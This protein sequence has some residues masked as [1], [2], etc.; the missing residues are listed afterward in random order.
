[1]SLRL[2]ASALA[3]ALAVP[4]GARADQ[5]N[6]GKIALELQLP[7]ENGSSG[8][9][10]PTDEYLAKFFNSARCACDV[11]GSEQLY[12][13]EYT[14]QTPPSV[15]P[16][17]P[18]E[19][20]T[21]IGCGALMPDERIARC[22]KG[23]PIDDPTLIDRAAQ[24]TYR[25][26]DLVLERGAMACPTDQVVTAQHWAV[27]ETS[28]GVWDAENQFP[29]EDVIADMQPPPLPEALTAESQEGGIRLTWS[30]IQARQDDIDVFQ[31]LCSKADGAP[32]H[33]MRTHPQQWVTT[34]DVC[35]VPSDATL[36]PAVLTNPMGD[37][38]GMPPAALRNLDVDTFICGQSTGTANGITLEGLQD[39]EAYWVVLLSIDEAGNLAGMYI[40]RPIT[41][42][43]V[44]DFWEELNDEDGGVQG[45]FCIASVGNGGGALGSAVLVGL[46]G[47]LAV[48]RRRRRAGRAARLALLALVL[49]PG[50]ASAQEAFSPYWLDEEET[51]ST[52]FIEPAWNVGV[53]FGPYRPSI[54]D[55]FDSSPGPYGRV[56]KK[57]SYLLAIDVHRLW[58]VARGQLGVGGTAGYFTNSALAF[59]EGSM[60]GDPN[61]P[62]AE[63][64]LTRLSIMPFQLTAIYRA[65][66]FD[67]EMGIPLVP[68]V[69]GGLGYYVWWA[70]KPN[71]ELSDD[72]SCAGCSDKAIGGSI[73]LVAAAGLAIRAERIDPDAARSMQ[74][75]GLEHAGFFAEVEAGWVDGFGN[76]QRLSL[77]DF[78]WF[79]GINF[80]F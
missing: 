62:R 4:A 78:T 25:V 8:F 80:E 69:R 16:S 52:G 47:L 59:E 17:E 2:L 60:P 11:G 18:V 41:P 77:G 23:D 54:D 7:P 31:A 21:G 22:T 44:I 64:N 27:T 79:G 67:D 53:R 19:I 32:A 43:S 40:D 56:F 58:S 13:I 26:K 36:V 15:P 30:A 10:E 45:G 39:Q 66:L 46:A 63:G 71:D 42:K 5:L 24:R 29:L 61:R 1:M 33:A 51:T 49:A 28:D 35:R 20:W 70:K 68:Y 48:R 55:K 57:D 50:A 73:G 6:G 38:V 14:W 74:D 9:T 3:V 75:S 72:M 34:Y 76:D 12:R 65:T 37:P